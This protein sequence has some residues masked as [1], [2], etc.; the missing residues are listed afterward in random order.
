MYIKPLG[1]EPL[2]FHGKGWDAQKNRIIVLFIVA[3]AVV[4]LLTWEFE[5]QRQQE[6]RNKNPGAQ[7]P[8]CIPKEL[9][10]GF[11][12]STQRC[13]QTRSNPRAA[14]E[15]HNLVRKKRGTGTQALNHARACGAHLILNYTSGQ[16]TPF[17]FDLCSAIN[18]GG[19][20]SGWRG[21]DV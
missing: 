8:S 14:N 9:P 10:P 6:E 15:T 7:E 19:N 5:K 3:A 2:S 17:T 20:P 21:Y 13:N 4:G 18:C 1:Q 11:H 12:N 16:T